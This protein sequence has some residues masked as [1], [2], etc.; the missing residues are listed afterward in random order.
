MKARKITGTRTRSTT[1][2]KTQRLAD[3]ELRQVAGGK[4][5]KRKSTKTKATKRKS[6]TY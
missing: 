1:T 3:S 5:T 4:A 2:K 6:T